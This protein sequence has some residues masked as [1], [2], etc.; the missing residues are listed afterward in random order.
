M[1]V[2]AALVAT[3]CADAD[4][5]R[6]LPT[7]PAPDTDPPAA[8]ATPAPSPTPVPDPPGRA[9]LDP[10][11]VLA[12]GPRIAVQTAG[13]Q[14][15]TMSEDG[16][17]QI[18]LTAASEGTVNRFPTWSPDASRLAWVSVRP[19]GDDPEIRSARFDGTAWL[20]QSTPT[21]PF[22]LSWD[23]TTTRIAALGPG[24]TGF[25][26]GVVDLAAPEPTYR[27]VDE[28]SP[29]WFSWSP[30][31]DEFLVH[32]SGI[33]LD[34]VPLDGSPQILERVPGAFQT[35][36]W[37]RGPVPLV[38]ADTVDD[39]D[40]LVV[41]G[42]QG[43]GRRAIAT[44]DGYLQFTVAATSGLIALQVLDPAVAPVP[45]TITAGFQADTVVDVVDVIPRDQ[46]T[47]MATFG[48][49]PIP[50]HPDPRSDRTEGPALAFV[51]SPDGSS[52]AWLI[53]VDPGSGCATETAVYEWRFWTGS[54]IVDGP[55]FVPSATFA[56][57]YV[58]F[59]DQFEQSVSFWSPDNTR[60]VYAGT[61]PDSGARGIFTHRIGSVSAPVRLAEG[62]LGVWSPDAAGSAATSAL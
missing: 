57:N 19:D 17:N 8:T 46:L 40:F 16:T 27:P 32:A 12:Q 49:D 20:Q 23:P 10:D 3:S 39:E 52:L 43:A 1:V 14:L 45:E 31:G 62:E 38:Y 13:G 44:Y 47:L 61:D 35:P 42:D 34:I 54:E 28:G 37:M 48:G 4:D 58:P 5:D 21:P 33:R 53:E 55:R 22:L 15:F 30:D 26:L 11:V 56:C 59:F 25:E 41:A 2:T 60:I 9:E 18:P 7:P 36:Q 51:W 50:L 29:F 6:A 24:A